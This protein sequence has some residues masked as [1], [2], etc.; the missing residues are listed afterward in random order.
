M[1]KTLS[2]VCPIRTGTVCRVRCVYCWALQA[3]GVSIGAQSLVR[4]SFPGMM[5][6][7]GFRVDDDAFAARIYVGPWRPLSR[8]LRT[9]DPVPAVALTTSNYD[10]ISSVKNQ[11][12]TRGRED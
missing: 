11:P 2:D 6:L 12:K 9:W 8:G 5:I 1:L 4:A 7:G 10:T 3:V